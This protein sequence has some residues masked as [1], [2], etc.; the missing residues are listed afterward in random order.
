MSG[1]VVTLSADTDETMVFEGWTGEGCSGTGDCVVTMDAARNVTAAF[2][3]ALDYPH[4]YIN[5]IGSD[6]CHSLTPPDLPVWTE[7]PPAE[8]RRP[9]DLVRQVED[10]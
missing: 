5:Y 9:G 10:R 1:T 7:G 8:F 6:S 2:T 3:Y 4:S